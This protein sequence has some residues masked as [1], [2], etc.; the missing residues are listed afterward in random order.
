MKIVCEYV[1]NDARFETN[2]TMFINKLGVLSWYT[3]HNNNF[4]KYV[5]HSLCLSN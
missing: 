5:L 3:T 1:M 2:Y 4:D